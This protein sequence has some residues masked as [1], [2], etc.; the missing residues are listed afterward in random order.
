M[1]EKIYI[2][3][4]VLLLSKEKKA[5]PLFKCLA[6]FF[7]VI[8]IQFVLNCNSLF[9]LLTPQTSVFITLRNKFRLS[10]RFL[11]LNTKRMIQFSISTFKFENTITDNRAAEALYCLSARSAISHTYLPN[12]L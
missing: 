2:K 9:S 8:S 4:P 11:H 12:K 10:V 1:T 5:L 3:L 7:V 6:S